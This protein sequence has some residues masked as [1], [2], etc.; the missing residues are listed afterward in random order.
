MSPARH[1]MRGRAAACSAALLSSLL[2]FHPAAGVTLNPRGLGQVLIYPY[3]TVNA[4]NSTLLSVVNTTQAGKALKLRFLEGY[5]GREVLTFNL[6]LSPFDVWVGQIYNRDGDA[7]GGATLGTYDTSCTNVEFAVFPEFPVESLHSQAFDESAFTGTNADGGPTGPE[8]TREGYFEI[9]E[10]GEVTDATHAT[11]SAITHINGVPANCPQIAAAWEGGGY[12]SI[13]ATAD[14]APPRGGLYGAESIINVAQGTLY[15]ANAVAIDGFSSTIQHTAQDNPAPDLNTASKSTDGTISAYVPF[16]GK[17][18]KADY[19]SSQDAISALFMADTLLNEYVIDQD[20]GA[21]S[22]WLVT[23]PTKRFYTDPAMLPAGA[24]EALRPFDEIFSANN[25]GGSCSQAPA[26]FFNREE[27]TTTSFG[28][29]FI[30]PTLPPQG[31][32][33][34]TNTITVGSSASVLGS[35]LFYQDNYGGYVDPTSVGFSSGHLRVHLT[36]DRFGSQLASRALSSG[37]GLTLTGLPAIGFMATNYVN[38]NVTAGILANY[39]GAYPHRVHVTCQSS[40]DP[41]APC[42]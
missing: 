42:D 22:D 34:A 15:A 8:R 13:D 37:N 38:A 7:T 3:Y 36:S 16:G 39:S 28:C 26:S 5:N 6:Y 17:L 10:M 12:W 30:C 11:L 31:F 20:V 19:A 21:A 25:V 9:I 23:F 18:V 27:L 14:L 32:C 29:G 2:A 1:R 35:Q 33:Y 41:Q 40:L 24:S 4:G